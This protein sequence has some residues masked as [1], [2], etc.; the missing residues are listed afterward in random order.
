MM[1][2]QYLITSNKQ[3][4]LNYGHLDLFYVKTNDQVEL[5]LR[6]QSFN[7]VKNNIFLG[8]QH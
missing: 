8:T 3:R 5:G 7:L 1:V 2:C 6:K 4:S